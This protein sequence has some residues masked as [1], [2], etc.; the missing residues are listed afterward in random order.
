M[1][2]QQIVVVSESPVTG[3]RETHCS[4]L[5]NID[6]HREVET[7][8]DAG[9][10]A[11]TRDADGRPTGLHSRVKGVACG[12]GFTLA[13]TNGGKVS[14]LFFPSQTGTSGRVC[15]GESP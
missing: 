2:P 11:R 3:A 6:L 13:V 10:G 1:Q 15:Q 12:G 7:L 14:I 8:G 5:V 4:T 9:E